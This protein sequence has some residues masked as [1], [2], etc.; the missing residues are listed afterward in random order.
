MSS[1]EPSTALPGDPP[2][3]GPLTGLRLVE[4]GGVGPV[5]F[6]TMVLRDLGVDVTTV[7]RPSAHDG[8]PLRAATG[9]TLNRG[10]SAVEL[11][12]RSDTG[13]RRTLDLITAADSVVEGFRPG[14]VERLGLGP[15]PCLEMNSRLVYGRMTGW[16]QDG[17]NAQLPGHDINYLAL[18]GALAAIGPAE[19]PVPPLNVVADFGGGGMLLAVGMLAGLLSSA[20]TGRGQVVDAA[21]LDGAA[22]Q[23]TMMYELWGRGAW[24]DVRGANVNDGG[25]PFYRTYETRDGRFVAVGA[26]ERGFYDRL[27]ELLGLATAD[28]PEQWDR[29]GWPVLS[30]ALAAVFRTRTRDEWCA[31]LK[32]EAV[33]VSPVLT[34]SEA[35]RHPHNAARGVFTDTGAAPVPAPAPRFAAG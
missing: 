34:M 17:P 35:A 24:S 19:R 10:R 33:C 31:L 21:M 2:T 28:L 23:M 12:L 26:L 25:A 20:R 18:S 9:D 32:H 16:G 27:V 13:R 7:T 11:D 15:G 3:G 4:L 8:D 30:D 22:L 29:A 5:P 6:C 1:G 14:A